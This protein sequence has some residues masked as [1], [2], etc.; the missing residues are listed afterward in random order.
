MSHS[1]E[2][3]R[4]RIL[5]NSWPK[6]EGAAEF[7]QTLPRSR[8]DNKLSKWNARATPAAAWMLQRKA[9]LSVELTA[10][11]EDLARQFDLG[12]MLSKQKPGEVLSQPPLRKTDGWMHQLAGYSHSIVKQAAMLSVCMGGG[13]SKI[14]VDLLNNCNSQTVLI[15]SPLSVM[16]VW[17]REFQKHSYKDFNVVILD[18]GTVLERAKLAAEELRRSIN[19]K[20]PCAIVTNYDSVWRPGLGDLTKTF[21]WDAVVCDES[22]RIKAH[23]SKVSKH[24]QDVGAVSEFRLCLT[25]TPM[26]H[27]PLDLF[28]QY[29][30]LDEGIFGTGYHNF[31]SRFATVNPR[32]PSK[33]EGWKNEAELRELFGLLAYSITQKEALPDLPPILHNSRRA[34]LCKESRRVYESLKRELMAEVKGGVVTVANA[35]VRTIRLQQI[36]SGYTQPDDALAPLLLGTEKQDLLRE[37]LE[38]IGPNEP[39]VVFGWF[40]EDM[41]RIAEVAR[42]MGLRYG[43]VS[44][45]RK[46]GLTPLATMRP[47]VDL[48]GVQIRA[49]SEGIDLTRARYGVFYGRTWSHGQEDQAVARLHRP[50]QLRHTFFYHL[51]LEDS[52]DV[53][54]R[55]A[56]K[57]RRGVAESIMRSLK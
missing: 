12:L 20:Q 17:R 16:G 33:V 9:P 38:D 36:C 46:D 55:R 44:G 42:S 2:L 48:L 22:H 21:P 54:M 41:N 26:P 18:H 52:I 19:A 25:G 39:V 6:D 7:Y 11:L 50:G 51:I 30:F 3:Q 5:V 57:E 8:W 15:A 27:S 47:D 14:T 1:A 40:R 49:G 28:G 4:G 37:L 24:M 10:E 31:V 53:D 32:F 45:V 34:K 23:N 43:E 35:L 29:R 56:V 13:K